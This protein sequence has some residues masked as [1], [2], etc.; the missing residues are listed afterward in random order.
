MANDKGK[1]FESPVYF[2]DSDSSWIDADYQVTSRETRKIES[3]IYEVIRQ[4]SVLSKKMPTVPIGRGKKEWIVE[5]D[6]EPEGPKFDDN[7][8][9]EDQHVTRKEELT[10]YV[11]YMHMDYILSMVDA[12]SVAYGGFHKM[13][14]PAQTIRNLTGSIVEFREK[15]FW[16][17]YDISGRDNAAANN[18]GTID[19]SVKGILNTSGINTFHAG[20]GDAIITTV[21]DGLIGAGNAVASLVEDDYFGP[22]D[23]YATPHVYSK[24]ITNANATSYFKSDLALIMAMKDGEG[25]RIFKSITPT[26]HLIPTVEASASEA[27]LVVIDPKDVNGAPTILLGESYPVMNVPNRPRAAVSASG[28]IVFAGVAGVLRP[29]AITWDENITYA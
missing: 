18:Q 9:K 12:D 13:S 17:G 28:K 25:N 15:V 16:R 6:V 24:L 19:T 22:Y 2:T 11:P 7:F 4:R 26:K 29:K 21:G 23:M 8:L 20:D 5:I 27:N 3:E 14:L 10:F 1:S